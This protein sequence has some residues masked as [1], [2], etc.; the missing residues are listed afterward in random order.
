MSTNKLDILVVN[1]HSIKHLYNLTK[2]LGKI[3]NTIEKIIIINNDIK[4]KIDLKDRKI[5]IIEN[6]NNQ[7]FAKAVNQGIKLSKSKFILL[8][9]PD[10]YLTNNSILHSFK[11]IAKNKKIGAIGGKIKKHKKNEFQPTANT[12]PTFKTALFEFTNLKKIF[13]DNKYTKKFW[14]EKTYFRKKPIEVDSLCGAFII[15]RKKNKK[16]YNF[17]DE[18]YFLYLEDLDFCL[19]LKKEGMKII[20]D[21]RSEITHIGGSSNNSKYKTVLKYWYKSRK[22]FFKKHLNKFES[23]IISILF[24]IEEKLL[25]LYHHLTNTPNE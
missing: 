14:I 7:G 10:T 13:P 1:Y 22:Y 20:F 4:E 24:D 17:F 15:F 8:L 5:K 12:H 11:I 16:K 6:K 19:S 2:S 25:T 23:F 18:N 3:E 9:N 21:P